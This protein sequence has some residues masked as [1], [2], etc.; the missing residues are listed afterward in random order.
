M[1]KK[2]VARDELH[3][4]LQDEFSKTAG[5]LCLACRLPLPTYFAGG[6]EGP[7]WRLPSMPECSGLCHTIV[8]E[9]VAKYS[10]RYDIAPPPSRG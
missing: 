6:K 1:K 10:E 3:A 8:E 7:N 2:T 5:D 9:L 4:L